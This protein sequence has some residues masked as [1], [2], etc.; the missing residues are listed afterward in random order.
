[1]P[2]YIQKFFQTLNPFLRIIN[3]TAGRNFFR[4]IVEH[5]TE[6]GVWFSMLR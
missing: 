1:M 4:K 6:D 2:D 5:Q 3:P